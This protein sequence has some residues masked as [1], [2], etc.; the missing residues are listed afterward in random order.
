M[1]SWAAAWP[2]QSPGAPQPGRLLR[3]RCSPGTTSPPPLP[4]RSVPLTPSLVVTGRR[5]P[6][7][8]SA[9][10]AGIT[11]R[12]SGITVLPSRTRWSGCSRAAP[13]PL[14]PLVRVPSAHSPDPRS[15]CRLAACGA[16]HDSLAPSIA[17]CTAARRTPCSRSVP[18]RTALVNG[19]SHS[20]PLPHPAV[21]RYRHTP[22]S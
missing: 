10:A 13:C 16:S 18:T 22:A 2:H 15:P 5:P 3:W 8:P 19:W 11:P 7:L 14:H 4:L 20:N 12:P 9:D 17:F 21:V 6:A 1:I